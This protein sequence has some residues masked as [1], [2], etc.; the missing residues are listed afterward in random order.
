VPLYRRILKLDWGLKVYCANN[1]THKEKNACSIL[2][3][4]NTSILGIVNKYRQKKKHQV[5][6]LSNL[7]RRRRKIIDSINKSG[8]TN[9]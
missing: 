8:K 9:I 7:D 3:Y 2:Y 1:L 6:S 5:P 4:N